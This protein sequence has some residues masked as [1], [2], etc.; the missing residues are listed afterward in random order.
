MKI[1]TVATENDLC[2]CAGWCSRGYGKNE[3]VNAFH[4]FLEVPLY[5]YFVFSSSPP[6]ICA[7]QHKV[8]VTSDGYHSLITANILVKDQNSFG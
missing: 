8:F 7:K 5:A 4:L 1:Y 2:G 6:L 3:S